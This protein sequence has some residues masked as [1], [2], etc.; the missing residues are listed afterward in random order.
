M[1]DK[2]RIAKDLMDNAVQKFMDSLL[3]GSE[4]ASAVDAKQEFRNY[5]VANL[6]DLAASC[7]AD[8]TGMPI[9]VAER[10]FSLAFRHHR[11]KARREG[12]PC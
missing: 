1:T 8:T 3:L 2:D 9:D 7:L 6:V 10:T 5:L 11:A 4:L 12:K